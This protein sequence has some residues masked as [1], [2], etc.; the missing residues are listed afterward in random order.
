MVC[1]YI[2]TLASR[3]AGLGSDILDSF[4]FTFASKH[5]HKPREKDTVEEPNWN[6]NHP[7]DEKETP[8]ASA[9]Q[10]GCICLPESPDHGSKDDT[11]NSDQ[12]GQPPQ[13]IADRLQDFGL[14][15]AFR[16]LS[17]SKLPNFGFVCPSQVIYLLICDLIPDSVMLAL[18]INRMLNLVNIIELNRFNF[19]A[20][21]LCSRCSVVFQIGTRAH[22]KMRRLN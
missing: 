7:S 5:G 11:R 4:V 1:A 8:S 9:S 12:V 21:H 22:A 15:T 16:W 19:R 13:R 20:S 6:A 3:L 17:H 2:K 10:K 18:L 14:A